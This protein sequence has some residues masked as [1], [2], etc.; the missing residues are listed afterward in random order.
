MINEY[1][2]DPDR[3]ELLSEIVNLK[4]FHLDEMFHNITIVLQ[5][6]VTIPVAAASGERSFSKLKFI[7][8]DYR[9]SD[10]KTTEQSF[11]S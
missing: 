7:E 1:K 6:F 8:N 2:P 5:I 10:S 3:T 9:T 4:K 11:S